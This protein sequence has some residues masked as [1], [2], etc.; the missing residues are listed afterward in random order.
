[1]DGNGGGL[2]TQVPASVRDQES[3]PSDKMEYAGFR[4]ALYL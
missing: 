3:N 2:G 1:M 4:I